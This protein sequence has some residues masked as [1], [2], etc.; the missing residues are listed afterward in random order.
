M[1]KKGFNSHILLSHHIPTEEW[2]S[3]RETK[4]K[5][6]KSYTIVKKSELTYCLYAVFNKNLKLISCFKSNT[7]VQRSLINKN[8]TNLI[9]I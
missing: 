4:T 1:A 7:G 8:I 5:K 9:F 2:N 6:L 3:V